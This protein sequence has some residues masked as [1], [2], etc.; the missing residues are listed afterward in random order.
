MLCEQKKPSSLTFTSIPQVYF[1]MGTWK[2][3][4][5][6]VTASPLHMA[7]ESAHRKLFEPTPRVAMRD[8]FNQEVIK[9]NSQ[10]H[11][12]P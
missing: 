8:R 3:A 9:S 1:F 7:L 11:R 6:E 10:D 12:F 5:G 4:L 2:I